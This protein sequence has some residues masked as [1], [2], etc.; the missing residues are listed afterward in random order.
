MKRNYRGHA[1]LSP[2]VLWGD[3]AT[4]TLEMMLASAQVIGHRAGRM[5]Q[6]GPAPNARDRREFA[7]MGQE[8]IEAGAQSAQAMLAHMMSMS[9]P[10]SALAFRHILRNS[11]AFMSLASSHTPTQVVARQAA[12]ARAVAQSAVSMAGV[13]RDAATLAHRG[14]KPIHARATAN[15]KRLGKR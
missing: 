4:K 15:A 9:Q 1:Y 11:A 6:A 8:K 7:L 2:F 10:W 13:S 12:L 14:L 5:A 3:L